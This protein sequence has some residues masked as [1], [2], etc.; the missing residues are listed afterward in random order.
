VRIF[1]KNAISDNS[2]SVLPDLSLPAK[3]L[4][5]KLILILKG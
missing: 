1:F 5:V 4:S 2:A 3:G